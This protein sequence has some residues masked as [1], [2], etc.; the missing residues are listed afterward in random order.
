MRQARLEHARDGLQEVV[1]AGRGDEDDIIVALQDH[2]VDA[3]LLAQVAM[4]E[5]MTHARLL[6]DVAHRHSAEA[7]RG[8]ELLGGLE[9][10]LG[11][12]RQRLRRAAGGLPGSLC[13][14]H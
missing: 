10:G 6:G 14:A 4:H 13:C 11:G 8:E 12:G 7:A 2:T 3:L 5:R 1:A 9:H